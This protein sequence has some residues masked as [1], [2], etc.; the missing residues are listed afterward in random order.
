MVTG[1]CAPVLF[2][3]GE[4]RSPPLPRHRRGLAACD[5]E[6]DPEPTGSDPTLKELAGDFPRRVA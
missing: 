4:T 1:P 6:P 5:P 2:G 3:A